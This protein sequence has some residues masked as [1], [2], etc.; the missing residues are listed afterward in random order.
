MPIQ[1]PCLDVLAAFPY[2]PAL[3]LQGFL[4]FSRFRMGE[5]ENSGNRRRLV[6]ADASGEGKAARLVRLAGRK[7]AAA[8]AF[9]YG[10]PRIWLLEA[11]IAGYIAGMFLFP[12]S[13]FH[14][15]WLLFA[16]AIPVCRWRGP[17]LNAKVYD[18]PGFWLVT[19]LLTWMLATSIFVSIPDIHPWQ[20]LLSL[21]D[22]AG[23]LFLYAGVSIL[24]RHRL[25]AGRRLLTPFPLAGTL[26]MLISIP[27]FYGLRETN[28]FPSARLRDV[29]VHVESGGLHQVLTGL[30]SGAAAMTAACLFTNR[31]RRGKQALVLFCFTVLVSSVFLTHTRGAILAL[32]VS[33][34]VYIVTRKDRSWVLPSVILA[35]VSLIYAFPHEPKVD[36]L[37]SLATS[38]V[39]NLIERGDGGRITLYKHLFSRMEGITEILL[40]K[41]LWANASA[42]KEQVGWSVAFHPHSIYM[43]TFYHGGAT[44]LLMTIGLIGFS[45]FRSLSVFRK[46]GDGTWL[47]LLCFGLTGQIVDGSLPFSILTIPRIEPILLIIPMVGSCAA[48][49]EYV[50]DAARVPIE[51]RSPVGFKNQLS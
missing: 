3:A 14:C 46:T 45:L 32:F 38:P 20:V 44:A 28:H 5:P 49:C 2:A 34:G 36:D 13:F 7:I 16:V 50:R 47:V 9:F 12:N 29:L 35:I 18:D 39:T 48:W 19:G 42:T 1:R 21:V 25:Q 24:V 37:S 6:A 33:F 26:A 43:A 11:G 22:A 40:G 17:E 8:V 30:L 4:V 41:G 15:L 31:A 10:E 27:V 51:G 23:V